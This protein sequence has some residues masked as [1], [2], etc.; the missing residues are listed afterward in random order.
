MSSYRV[1]K[2]SYSLIKNCYVSKS[3]ATF[4]SIDWAHQNSAKAKKIL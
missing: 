3:V 2:P 4:S 1:G